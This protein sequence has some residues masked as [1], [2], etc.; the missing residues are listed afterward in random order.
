MSY[1]DLALMDN[2]DEDEVTFALNRQIIKNRKD[3]VALQKA[4]KLEKQL[5]DLK[6]ISVEGMKAVVDTINS[7]NDNSKKMAF[8]HFDQAEVNLLLQRAPHVLEELKLARKA[9][10]DQYYYGT[11]EDDYDS[12]S[13]GNQSENDRI[14][15]IA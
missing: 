10:E 15:Q 2:F 4:K 3:K 11:N 14:N 7:I 5:N 6:L 13:S 9:T 8:K 1:E 12:D